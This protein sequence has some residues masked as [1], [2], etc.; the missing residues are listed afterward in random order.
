MHGTT[1]RG[2]VGSKARWT[3]LWT[4]KSAAELVE[5]AVVLPLLFMVLFGM[6][7]FGR[8]FNIY[9]TMARATREGAAYGSRPVCASCGVGCNRG[10]PCITGG[11]SIVDS[12]VTPTLAADHINVSDLVRIPQPSLPSCYSDVLTQGNCPVT[13]TGNLAPCENVQGKIWVCR[14]V[15]MAPNK[16]VGSA[17]ACGVSVSMAYPWQFRFPFTGID[18]VIFNI[19]ASA[20]ERQEF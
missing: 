4:D 2:V 1:Q 3:R 5:F 9:E 18:N 11:S 10:F 13:G 8:A 16:A 7:W 6:W 17:R 20:V 15:D 12:V 19:P 14:C